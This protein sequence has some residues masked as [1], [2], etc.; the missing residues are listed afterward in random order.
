MGATRR[1]LLATGATLPFGTGAARAATPIRGVI[2]LFTSQGCSSCPPADRLMG[3][4]AQDPS[5]VVL[6]LPVDYWDGLGWR[7]TFAQAAFTRRQRAYASQ[8]GDGEVYTPQAVVNGAGIAVG[9]D[10]GG[11]LAKLS[12]LPVQVTLTRAG[13]GWIGET[14]NAPADAVLVLAPFLRARSVAIGRGEN[15]HAH[16]T[17]TNIV[18]TLSVLG[19]TKGGPRFRLDMPPDAEGIALLVQEGGPERPGRI[20]GAART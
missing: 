15:A 19:A 10:R 8:R 7:D 12:P 3:E 2:E 5:L 16:V 9:S 4:L 11:I 20:L 17:Y 6:S 1:T 18:Q 14:V 13:T